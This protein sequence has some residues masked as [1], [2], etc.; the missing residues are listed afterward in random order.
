MPRSWLTTPVPVSRTAWANTGALPEAIQKNSTNSLPSTTMPVGI[1]LPMT[2]ALGPMS[3]G[4]DDGVTGPPDCDPS[5]VPVQADTA[6]RGG[7]SRSSCRRIDP[8]GRPAA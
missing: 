7:R 5:L 4:I 6:S 2:G 8:P 3:I 1:V